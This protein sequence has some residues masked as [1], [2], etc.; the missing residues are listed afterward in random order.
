MISQCLLTR[1]RSL[2][3]R[4]VILLILVWTI[5]LQ[6]LMASDRWSH[7]KHLKPD[8]WVYVTLEDGTD[9]AGRFISADASTLNIS[10][11]EPGAVAI[12]RNLV[13]S[14]A[15]DKK[16]R[17]WY[18]IPLVLLVGTAGGVAGLIIA[19]HTA[20]SES[21]AANGSCR[22]AKGAIIALTAAGPAILTYRATL[23][24]SIR[25]MI[26]YKPSSTKPAS[27]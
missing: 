20:C 14:V 10:A 26:Y 9:K 8:A 11:G 3:V 7:V 18:S 6:S 17:P 13:L 1:N 16:G 23:G 21:S 19:D 12:E 24:T 4:H 25:K 5:A 27:K 15:I 22:K 2:R